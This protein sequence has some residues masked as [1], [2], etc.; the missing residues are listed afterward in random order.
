MMVECRLNLITRQGM[1]Y[2]ELTLHADIQYQGL[3]CKGYLQT[4]HT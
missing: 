1:Y 4:Q 2:E 3:L